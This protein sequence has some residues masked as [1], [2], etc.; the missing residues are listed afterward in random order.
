VHSPPLQNTQRSKTQPR[1]FPEIAG[2][3]TYATTI[4]ITIDTLIQYTSSPKMRS[5]YHYLEQLEQHLPIKPSKWDRKYKIAIFCVAIVFLIMAIVAFALH[6]RVS[7]SSLSLL[8][9]TCL[10]GLFEMGLIIDYCF[11]GTVCAASC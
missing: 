9:Q 6:D 11:L 5:I 4:A 1:I 8:L 10:H 2:H 7:F 3:T